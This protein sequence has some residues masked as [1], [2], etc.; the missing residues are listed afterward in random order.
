LRSPEKLQK[1][2]LKV[3]K[4]A[5]TVT[6]NEKVIREYQRWTRQ[7]RKIWEQ[8]FVQDQVTREKK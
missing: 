4:L 6:C 7:A 8:D 3:R 2:L 5:E 1:R